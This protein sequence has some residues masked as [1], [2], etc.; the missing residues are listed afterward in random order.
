MSTFIENSYVDLMDGCRM[1]AWTKAERYE[2][3]DHYTISGKRK[4]SLSRILLSV[5]IGI[6]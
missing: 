5:L 2:Y 4:H 3:C 6:K 1:P